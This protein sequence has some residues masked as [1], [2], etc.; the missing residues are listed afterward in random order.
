MTRISR[1]TIATTRRIC[2]HPPNVVV[3]TIPSS[4][5]AMSRITRN[6]SIGVSLGPG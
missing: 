1:K 4:Q 3:V 5:N 6:I 2:S